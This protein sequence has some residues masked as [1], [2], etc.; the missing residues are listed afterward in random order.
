MHG[1]SP[2]GTPNICS[3]SKGGPCDSGKI[4]TMIGPRPG[5]RKPRPLDVGTL[6]SAARANI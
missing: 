5:D 3:F 2:K 6:V 1:R 4:K